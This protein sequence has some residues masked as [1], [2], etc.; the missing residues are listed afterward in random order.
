MSESSTFADA[1]HGRETQRSEDSDT[2]RFIK[3]PNLP[4]Q[5][6]EWT[7][8]T[9]ESSKCVCIMHKHSSHA[10][11]GSSITLGSKYVCND[12]GDKLHEEFGRLECYSAAAFPDDPQIG[13][14]VGLA[15]MTRAHSSKEQVQNYLQWVNSQDWELATEQVPAW[16]ERLGT[17]VSCDR[18]PFPPISTDGETLWIST[19]HHPTLNKD[20][21]VFMHDS[22]HSTNRIRQE[23]GLTST[24]VFPPRRTKRAPQKRDEGSS[25]SNIDY[26][27]LYDFDVRAFEFFLRTAS[28]GA[29]EYEQRDRAYL[30]PHTWGYAHTA[31]EWAES[32]EYWELHLLLENR[33]LI[34]SLPFL[35][36][37]TKEFRQQWENDRIEEFNL[38]QGTSE[39]TS[40]CK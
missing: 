23:K 29:D 7:A 2:R 20:V 13:L 15:G 25:S 10:F 17:C 6:E 21:E 9:W 24:M 14:T 36:G 3:G 22:C 33:G 31:P 19:R 40:C 32:Q 39:P 30:V 37:Q 26:M 11:Y 16:V 4:Y 5:P 28:E 35:K 18:V 12:R 8:K 34:A 1:S 38:L 27:T